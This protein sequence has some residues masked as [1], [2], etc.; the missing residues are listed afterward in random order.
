MNNF[1]QWLSPA[2]KQDDI[3]SRIPAIQGV[4][5]NLYA[6]IHGNK[7]YT[8]EVQGLECYKGVSVWT[9][10]R[11]FKVMSTCITSNRINIAIYWAGRTW[12]N[13][14]SGANVTMQKNLKTLMRSQPLEWLL[15][16][17]CSAF[18]WWSE[19]MKCFKE[20]KCHFSMRFLEQGKNSN[21][22][23]S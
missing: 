9:G 17:L 3:L 1:Y 15:L 7:K 2:R 21:I 4:G 22:P 10:I 13:F 8:V 18:L 23:I 5:K 14:W 16:F 19:G 20:F 12:G 11:L 6:Q